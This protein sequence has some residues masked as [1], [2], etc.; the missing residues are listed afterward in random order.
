ML[1]IETSDGETRLGSELFGFRRVPIERG[2]QILESLWGHTSGYAIPQFVVDAPGGG[3]KIPLLPDY[4]AGEGLLRNFEGRLFRYADAGSAD[5]P[6]P[7][8]CPQC[9]G[10]HGPHAPEPFTATAR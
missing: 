7:A 4:R 8:P 5:P 1:S 6:A 9:G 10:R 3:G 2:L